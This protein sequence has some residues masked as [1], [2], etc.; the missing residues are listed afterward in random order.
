MAT[1]KSAA[2]LKAGD[3]IDHVL[4]PTESSKS[5]MFAGRTRRLRL[6]VI[7]T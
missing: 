2:A 1:R 7:A 4:K 6:R 5:T 3:Q